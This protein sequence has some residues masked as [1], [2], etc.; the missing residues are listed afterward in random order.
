MFHTRP[1]RLFLL[2]S[3]ALVVFT[4]SAF[5][6]ADP[7]DPQNKCLTND[8]PSFNSL[9]NLPVP[10][11]IPMSRSNAQGYDKHEG[12]HSDELLLNKLIGAIRYG[13]LRLVRDLLNYHPWLVKMVDSEKN[14]PLHHAAQ[15]TDKNALDIVAVL[16]E[17]QGKDGILV[18]NSNGDTPLC[19]AR[20]YAQAE[21]K[22]YLKK[23]LKLYEE[24]EYT[25]SAS[26]CDDLQDLQSYDSCS[27]RYEW[28]N[29]FCGYE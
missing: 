7:C 8:I 4:K 17:I 16:I 24:R 27:D 2:L 25:Q 11:L 20:T 3:V 10:N 12:G 29:D 28:Q 21:L 18:E 26:D 15:S 14:L 5:S 19:L 23:I 13:D 9:R 22:N 6:Y 1:Y